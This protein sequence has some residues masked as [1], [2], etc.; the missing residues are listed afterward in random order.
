[1]Y[2]DNYDTKYSII[3]LKTLIIGLEYA[4]KN[5]NPLAKEISQLFLTEQLTDNENY[6]IAKNSNLFKFFKTCPL[7]EEDK[8][9]F[10][11][12]ENAFVIARI[13][14]NNS[15][16]KVLG[17]IL[18]NVREYIL[19]DNLNEGLIKEV[20]GMD[21]KLKNYVLRYNDI[22]K[23]KQKLLEEKKIIK[24]PVLREQEIENIKGQAIISGSSKRLR[25]AG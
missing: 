15:M 10:S 6:H 11:M 4:S 13:Q 1:M 21:S 19:T 25:K 24:F 3:D 22:D 23:Y 8:I 17:Q 14:N 12:I 18:S 2:T 16:L 7:I 5:N 20:A 9:D